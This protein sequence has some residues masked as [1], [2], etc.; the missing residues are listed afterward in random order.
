MNC[1]WLQHLVEYDCNPCTSLH[2]EPALDVRTPFTWIDGE[3]IGFFVIDQGDTVMISDNADTLFHFHALGMM[4]SGSRRQWQAVRHIAESRGASMSE[5]G[6][7]FTVGAKDKAAVLIANFIAGL[8]AISEHERQTSGLDEHVSLF[9]DEV[10]TWLRA[11]KPNEILTKGVLLRGLSKREHT[12]DFRLGNRVVAAV[13]PNPA[14]I[15]GL[16]RK[17]GDAL[18]GP[19]AGGLELLAVIDDR[20]DPARAEEETQIVSSLIKAIPLSNLIS[21]VSRA[22][23]H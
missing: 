6:E 12:F 7:I 8:L 4:S 21:A 3:P 17:V 5:Q 20:E 23:M 1:S 2:G 13:Q 14:A 11:W 10:E 18:G 16:M 19:D 9:A 22:R 15:G